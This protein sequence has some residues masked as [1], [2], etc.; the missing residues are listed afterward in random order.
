MTSRCE[1]VESP[2]PLALPPQ[3]LARVA[4]GKY[5]DV[6]TGLAKIRQQGPGVA[7]YV[8]CVE[9]R[10]PAA[11]NLPDRDTMLGFSVDRQ[12]GA[13]GLALLRLAS[14]RCFVERVA[15]ASGQHAVP[16]PVSWAGV[17]HPEELF[18]MGMVGDSPEALA[19]PVPARLHLC[20]ALTGT[21]LTWD[22]M[23]RSVDRGGLP[24]GPTAHDQLSQASPTVV[25]GVQAAR[26]CVIRELGRPRVAQAEFLTDVVTLSV[27]WEAPQSD[28]M[29]AAAPARGVVMGGLLHRKE[30]SQMMVG[31]P[32]LVF[33]NQGD[34]RAFAARVTERWR[35]EWVRAADADDVHLEAELPSGG[36]VDQDQ[37]VC[38]TQPE[39]GDDPAEDQGPGAMVGVL[40]SSGLRCPDAVPW[41]LC[42]RPRSSCQV[43]VPV[44][45]LRTA[46]R[47]V[48]WP[49]AVKKLQRFFLGEALGGRESHTAFREFNSPRWDTRQF[50]WL[51]VFSPV[52][53][54]RFPIGVATGVGTD[55]LVR[56]RRYASDAEG[57]ELEAGASVLRFLLDEECL[58]EEVRGVT[59][60]YRFSGRSHIWQRGD[61]RTHRHY[62]KRDCH[63]LV[64]FVADEVGLTSFTRAQFVHLVAACLSLSWAPKGALEWF[65]LKEEVTVMAHK[66][67]DMDMDALAVALNDSLSATQLALVPRKKRD[68]EEELV[69]LSWKFVVET[70]RGG[71]KEIEVSAAQSYFQDAVKHGALIGGARP[72]H[73]LFSVSPGAVA[74]SRLLCGRDNCINTFRGFV[75]LTAVDTLTAQQSADKLEEFVKAQICAGSDADFKWLQAFLCAMLEH[76]E[77]RDQTILIFMGN[78][79]TGKTIMLGLLCA[80]LTT[81]YSHF[82]KMETYT[83]KFTKSAR[84]MVYLFD[85]MDMSGNALKNAAAIERIVLAGGTTLALEEHRKGLDSVTKP[86]NQRLI[87]TVNLEAQLGRLASN[88]RTKIVGRPEGDPGGAGQLTRQEAKD[89]TDAIFLRDLEGPRTMFARWLTLPHVVAAVNDDGWDP[90]PT[91]AS[92]MTTLRTMFRGQVAM[93]WY[94]TACAGGVFGGNTQLHEVLVGFSR[95]MLVDAGDAVPAGAVCEAGLYGVYRLWAGQRG[96]TPVKPARFFTDTFSLLGSPEKDVSLF[97]GKLNRQLKR[98]YFARPERC[99]GANPALAATVGSDAHEDQIG[100]A[101]AGRGGLSVADVRRW[102]SEFQTLLDVPSAKGD[103]SVIPIKPSMCE[104]RGSPRDMAVAI[105]KKMHGIAFTDMFPSDLE[106][107]GSLLPDP[108]A[109]AEQPAEATSSSSAAARAARLAAADTV[110]QAADVG[111]AASFSGLEDRQLSDD[112]QV[113]CGLLFRQRGDTGSESDKPEWEDVVEAVR[114]VANGADTRLDLLRGF[115]GDFDILSHARYT[116]WAA[117]TSGAAEPT[118]EELKQARDACLEELFEM[119]RVEQQRRA[120]ASVSSSP[121]PSRKR[122]LAGDDDYFSDDEDQTV[123][124]ELEAIPSAEEWPPRR[125]R[126]LA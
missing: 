23:E 94:D 100:I 28:G 117:A 97:R 31:F 60:F 106:S 70:P 109:D 108:L 123:Q 43:F 33:E 102:E 77:R 107:A 3:V 103:G 48:V 52:A 92:R 32:N 59:K 30:V 18:E 65:Q 93:F 126:R 17:S 84:Q 87:G 75:P 42:R 2:S 68:L 44:A 56:L 14:A 111:A 98:Y 88:R 5:D 27:L 12:F 57:D 24:P 34:M 105:C 15:R 124:A 36:S 66:R 110:G 21:G 72:F 73:E 121:P 82:E 29:S 122:S 99:D 112:E 85:E 116:M 8:S 47:G 54:C 113:A 115:A 25:N 61:A 51:D 96:V 91:E 67:G 46:P 1:V 49:A 64:N 26:T 125:R 38:D 19:R 78:P 104:V 11:A 58:T 79:G 45:V 90:G 6:A 41:P 101:R 4:E 39:F 81:E 120:R 89:I 55:A 35:R 114:E 69:G 10:A 13:G 118:E 63:L 37:H 80:L 20:L 119:A 76:P 40:A 83:D 9:T 74:N 62:D 86:N 50:A 16:R 71:T 22:Q 95:W 7:A 53:C